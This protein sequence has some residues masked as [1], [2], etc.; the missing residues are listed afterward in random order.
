VAAKLDK[1]CPVFKNWTNRTFEMNE[2]INFKFNNVAIITGKSSNIFVIDVDVNDNG[3]LYF[4]RFCSKHNYRYDMDTTCVLTPSG[5]I[6]LYY[7]YNEIF[8]SNSV[9]LKTTDSLGNEINVGIDIRSNGGCVVAPP[10]KYPKG[11]YEFLC[12]KRPQECPEFMYE[13]INASSI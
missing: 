10:S 13:L 11:K 12:M 5:G 8:S 1:K 7:I 6:H 3:L 4:Q 2:S 9:R